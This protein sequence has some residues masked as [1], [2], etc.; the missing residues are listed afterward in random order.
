MIAAVRTSPLLL[1]LA[2]CGTLAAHGIAPPA[3]STCD[4]TG[5]VDPL[6]TGG[7]G[8]DDD[9]DDDDDDGTP[10]PA[11]E[12]CGNGADDDDDGAT[13]CAD[14]DCL[15]TCDADGDGVIA[16]ALGGEDCDDADP[17]VHP[18]AYEVCDGDDSDCDGEDCLSWTDGFEAAPAA[19]W[20]AAGV[21]P[22]NLHLASA[23][24]YE[25]GFSAQSG[26]VTHYE[27]SGLRVTVTFPAA[28][29]ISFWRLVS[30]EANY[31]W[32]RFYVDGALVDQ[33]SGQLAWAQ[34]SY[35]A[36]AGVHTLEWTYE[37]DVSVN[38]GNDAA[39]IDL[40]EI[41]GGAP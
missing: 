12:E 16:L 18:Y 30:S 24:A 21:A 1:L 35:P 4:D 37:K 9:D 19:V 23:S 26:L 33:W 36:T 20:S 11:V 13:D 32:L 7:P 34:A 27:T 38:A 41:T 2:A 40:V 6:P 8:G 10:I 17:Y 3:A 39:W 25:G 15:S 29:T 5:C 28:G 31:D 14:P 22:W